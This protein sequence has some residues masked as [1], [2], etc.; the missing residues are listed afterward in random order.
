MIPL[1]PI[2]IAS[3]TQALSVNAIRSIQATASN[4]YKAIAWGYLVSTLIGILYILITGIHSEWTSALPYG[5]FTGFFYIVSLIT[6]IRSM[7]QRGLAITIAIA[8]VSMVMPVLLAIIGGDKPSPAQITGICLAAISIP[9]LTL[10]TASGRFINEKPSIKFAIF[11]FIVRGL[12]ACGN[13]VAEDS[14]P[15][16]VLPVYITSLFGSCFILSMINLIFVEKKTAF[17]D[18]KTGTT[19]GVLNIGATSSLIYALTK[20]AGS[21]VFAAYNA[22]G[23]SFSV[24]FAIGLWKERIKS[25]GWIGF[26]LALLSTILMRIV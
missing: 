20:V 22:L 16:S 15:A 6:M 24:L 17:S 4:V 25:W 12:A 23:I 14:L 9:I 19:F 10:S 11:L 3:I 26:G 21:I 7:G 18:F 5:I 2:L 1:L 8:N 13:L